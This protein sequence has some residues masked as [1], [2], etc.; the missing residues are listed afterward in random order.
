MHTY[1]FV[2]A[3]LAVLSIVYGALMAL[4]ERDLKRIVAYAS[5][6]HLGFI[7][8]GIFSLTSNGING[9]VIQIINHGIIISAL[10]LIVGF[11]EARTGTRELGELSGLERRMPWLYVFFL[12]ATLAGLGM[13]GMNSFVG[14]FA[15]MLGAFQL[16]WIYAV[17]AGGGVILACWY[18]L[19]LHQGLMHDPL[20]PRGEGVHDL[21]LGEALL[22]VPL[23]ALMIFIGL[24]PKPISDVARGS[25][26][27]YVALV[28]PGTPT[29]GAR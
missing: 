27:S 23:V 17:L 3:A 10:F 5:I 21:H 22:L 14:E 29:T 7:S 26:S 13:P 11:I 2:L 9:A 19:R 16:N 28:Q 20:R 24:Y 4:S 25:V 6:S 18:M 1:R 12:V 8:L 15:I